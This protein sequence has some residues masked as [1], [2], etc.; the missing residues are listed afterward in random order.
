MPRVMELR[1][2]YMCSQIGREIDAKRVYLK[3]SQN[4]LAEHLG[5]TQQNMSKK[6][7][8]NKFNYEDLIK[9]F[10]VLELSDEEILRLMKL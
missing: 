6:I 5:T 2:R 10:K 3:M 4:E 7:R 9:A 8:M 1:P